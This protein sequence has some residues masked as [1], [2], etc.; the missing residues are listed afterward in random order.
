MKTINAYQTSDGQIFENKLAAEKHEGYLANR[1]FVEKFLEDAI[2]PYRAVPQ[3]A[4]ARNTII[5]W[6]IWCAKNDV[7]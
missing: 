1:A 2:N 4:I 3:K 5:N 7:K 6:S